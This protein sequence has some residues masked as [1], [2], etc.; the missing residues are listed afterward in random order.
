MPVV[1]LIRGDDGKLAGLTE[2]D[3]RGF[4]RF[5]KRVLSLGLSCITFEWREPRSGPAHRR[6][7]GMVNAAFEAQER[8]DDAEQFRVWLQIGA[9]FCEFL[10][11][12][13][14]GLIAIPR[15]IAFAKLDEVEFREVADAVWTFYR[16]EH[17]RQ[18]LYPHLD[19][20]QSF[21][22]VC[23]VLEEFE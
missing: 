1:T 20:A 16:S 2:K 14:R 18:L 19:E 6:Y 4:A 8:F 9:G 13:E 22:M 15:S 10:P 7:F 21:D 3:Q 23:S 5:M 12:P 17:A 11:H